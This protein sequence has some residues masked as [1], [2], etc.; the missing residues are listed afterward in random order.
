MNEDTFHLGIKGLIRQSD[1]KILLLKVNTEKLQAEKQAY[2]DLPGG[3]IQK[4]HTVTDTLQREIEEETGVSDLQNVKS[5]GMVLSNIRIPVTQN[6]SVGL[7][8][9]I[10]ECT[11]PENATIALSDEHSD[12]GWFSP[13]EAAELLE[14]KYP[15]EFCQEVAQLA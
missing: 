12:L 11:I 13:K 4:D 8:L 10:Y 3:R 15:K 1:G 9:G 5:V 14:V 7:I 2:W 6:D